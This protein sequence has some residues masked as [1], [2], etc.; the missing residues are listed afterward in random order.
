MPVQ[1]TQSTYIRYPDGCKVEYS[2]NGT[3]FVDV[4]V[5]NSA[6]TS[7][8]EWD[9][10]QVNTANGGMLDKQIRNMRMSGAFTLINL[11]PT[12]VAALSGGALVATAVAGTELS[13][14]PN[15]TIAAS[16]WTNMQRIPF[17]PTT[18][19]GIPLR[20]GSA[21]AVTSITASTSGALAANDDYYIVADSSSF[22]G[23]SLQMYTGGTATVATT[24][25]VVIVYAANTPTA[26]V[27]INGGASTFV[28]TP[29]VLRF[30][31]TDSVAKTRSLTLWS[32][33]QNSGGFQFNFKGA[34]E[35]GVEEMPL[36]YTAMLD[37][38]RTTG[39]QLFTWSEQVG[40]A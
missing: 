14:I 31:H 35:D 33:N 26:S 36:S 24:E 5:I 38:S 32:V 16:S 7:T 39:Q 23:Y 2:L 10:N 8:L 34:N 28:L 1:T 29:Y 12:A 21:P 3:D 11:N 17:A 4:G 27:T 30:T 9:E 19:A 37:T 40:A 15:Q 18:A 25:S 13:D 22:S 20:L 6:V